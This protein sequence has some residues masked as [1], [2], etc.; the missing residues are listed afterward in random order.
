[1]STLPTHVVL[2]GNGV[3][4]RETLL[5]LDRRSVPATS[6]GR[7]PSRVPSARSVLADLLDAAAVDGALR[8]AEVAYLTAGLP[9]S[10]RTWAARW[11]VI[12]Q[13]TIEA[14]I[15]RGVR[16]VYLD[17]VYAYGPVDGPM[18][19]RTPVRPSSRKGRVRANALQALDDAATRRGLQVTVAR[20][21]DFYGPGATTSVFNSF[22]LDHLAA[23]RPC[24]WLLDADQPHSLTYTP[25]LGE[26]LAII[27]TVP[28]TNGQVW[29]VPT[30][31]AS[32]IRDY[33]AIAA[34]TRTEVKVMNA[35][36]LRLGAVFNRSARETLEMSYQYSAP[37]RFNSTAFETAFTTVPTP[38]EVGIATVLAGTAAT[39]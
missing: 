36:T 31:A 4:G 6:V 25:D 34:G 19:E 38:I 20:S 13:N 26:A 7:S 30:A 37:Y 29:H 33:A 17:N 12:V 28:A 8:G 23:K 14:A 27:G 1:M 11:P 35:A 22:V 16:L 15:A 39:R 5:A 24:S 18:T 9:Y 10:A 3:A 21:G 32:T 2:G